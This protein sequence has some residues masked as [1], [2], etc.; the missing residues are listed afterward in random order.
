[1]NTSKQ[2]NVMI[3]LMF[4]TLIGLLLYFI[5]DDVRAEDATEKQLVENAERGGRLFSLNCRSCHGLNGLGPLENVNLP[6]LPLNQEFNRPDELGELMNRQSRMLDTIRCGRVGTVMPAWAE[7]QGGSLNDFQ[8]QQ[9]VALITGAM[10]GLDAPHHHINAVSEAGWEAAL[11]DADHSDILEGKKL[12]QSV[13]PEDTVFVLTNAQELIV[14]SLIRIDDEAVLIIDVPANGKLSAKISKDSTDLEVEM[15]G[16]LFTAGDVVKVGQELMRVVSVSDG[17]VQVE[18]GAF[19]TDARGHRVGASVFEPSDEILVERGAFATEATEHNE[20]TQLFVGPLEPPTGPLTG[21]SGEVP[22]G[23]R[24]AAGP[25][26]AASPTPTGSPTPDEGPAAIPVEGVI[27][28]EMG[29]NFF[30]FDGQRNPTLQVAVGQELTVKLTNNGLAI[31]NMRT[32]GEDNEYNTDDDDVS[33]PEVVVAG[34]TATLKFR[35]DKAGTF[36]FRCDFHPIE[37]FGQIVVT[38]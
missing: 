24:G 23:Q 7:D 12:A 30:Q 2:V 10:P 29:D 6:G 16:D 18:R 3:G 32:A 27:S 22:C 31:H 34:D 20:G 19:D 5:W 33:D 28:I 21:E 14:D 4:V 38:E 17:V 26:V 25:V 9:L 13:G 37:M 1:M 15:A 8:I 11:E 35:F 36:D